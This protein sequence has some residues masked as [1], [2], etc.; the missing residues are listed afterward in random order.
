MGRKRKH[1]KHLPR[2]V[3]FEGKTYYFRR[4]HGQ[5]TALGK[6]L[7]DAMTSWANLVEPESGSIHTMKALF[8]RYKLE[9]LPRKAEKT[10]RNQSYMFPILVDV[11][12][13]MAPGAIR[14]KHIYEFL[15]RRGRQALTS[16][17]KE[18]N[19]LSHCLTKAVQW[20]LID[21]NPCRHVRRD[22]Y[23][24]KPRDRYVTDAEFEI[25]RKLAPERIQ[26][27]MDL[28][29]LTGLRRG[30]ILALRRESVTDDGLLIHTA[31]T[32]KA[33]LMEW[34]DELRAVVTRAQRLDPRVRAPL[35]CTLG[36]RAY[37]GDGFSAIWQRVMA[38]AVKADV[39]RFTFHDL[40]AKSASDDELASA[41]ARLGHTSQ[42]ITKRVYVRKPT[43]VKPLR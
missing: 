2:G 3:T 9:V 23:R 7:A 39:E 12:G 1:D 25:V 16:A 21:E 35:L 38:K 27:A 13:D 24:P 10:Q 19:L 30:D 17:N 22:E 26:I 36:G 37:T 42:A 11:F 31:K 8:E 32:G 41:S 40:R 33:L 34:T 14:P 15:S 6:T 5:R 43:K 29:V 20:G 4:G 18:M 28:A